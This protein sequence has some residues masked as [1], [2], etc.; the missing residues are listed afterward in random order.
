MKFLL[1]L[2]ILPLIAL[3]QKTLVIMGDSLSDGYGIAKEN[4]FPALLEKELPQWKIVNA[5][6]SGSTSASGPDRISWVLKS[7]PNAVLI[8]L[9][10]NDGLRGLEPKDLKLNLERSIATLQKEKVKVLLAGI[11]APP[12]YGKNYAKKFSSVY[13]QISKEKK[14]PLYPFLLEGIAGNPNL[15]L[16]D[17]IHPNEAG[18]QKLAQNILKFLKRELP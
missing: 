11:K 7:K 8:A 15:N 1:I 2:F 6:I 14:I 5:S 12:N 18:H 9:G 16:A 3:A 10:G 13:S 4:S 17:G